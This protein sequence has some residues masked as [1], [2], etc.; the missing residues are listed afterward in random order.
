MNGNPF[1]HL[2][3][4]DQLE[5]FYNRRSEVRDALRLLHKSQSVGVTGPRR[6]GKTSF[7]RYI[8]HPTILQQHGLDLQHNLLVYIDCQHRLIQQ[9]EPQ[10]YMM[11]LERIAE[12][13]HRTGV[14]F[15]PGPCDESIAGMAFESALRELTCRGLRTV[16]L[17]DE[18]EDMARNAHLGPG[19]FSNLRALCGAD[20][21]DVAYV[22]A[23]CVSLADLCLERR[24]LLSSPFFNIFRPIR[25]GLFSEQDSRR[26]VED[27]LRR[28]G[29][30]FP[31]DLLELVL[32]VGGGYPF[33]LQT[34]AYCAFDLPVKGEKL[35]EE[36]RRAFVETVSAQFVDHFRSY[37]QKLGT[38]EQY[39]LA[40]LPLVWREIS[41]QET[42]EHLRDQ[43]LIA[44]RNGGYGYFSPLLEAFVRRQQVNGLLQAGPLLVDQRREQV[45]LRGELLNLSPINYA[46][47]TYLMHRAGQVV[48]N[49]ELWRAAWSDEPCNADQQ[50]KSS[51][52]SLRKTLGDVADCIVTRRGIGYIFQF[53]LK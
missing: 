6:I 18:F 5:H 49:E 51:I 24:S 19:F 32:E 23:S 11:M 8:S 38:Q 17:L 29:A 44:R 36:E 16:L 1:Y 28:A 43:C 48:S 25:L 33:F 15:A 37:W 52:K 39:V 7:L 53:P 46:L 45:L 50:L 40:A 35:T 26:L 20:D 4:I 47:L 12:V 9:R 13:A 42:I 31:R 14:D 2:A 21:M 30:S 41:Y 3:A 27:S 34:A 22:T 10:V